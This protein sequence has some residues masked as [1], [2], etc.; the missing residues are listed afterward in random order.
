MEVVEDVL[1]S[2]SREFALE[3]TKD[4][5][6]TD[7][8]HSRLGLVLETLLSPRGLTEATTIPRYIRR[9]KG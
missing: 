5:V 9:F 8:Y 1:T 3:S 4:Y 2:A 7:T 6:T